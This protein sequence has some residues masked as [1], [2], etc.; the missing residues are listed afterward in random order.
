MSTPLPKA[1]RPT[2]VKFGVLL[3][4][5]CWAVYFSFGSQKPALLAAIDA[6]IVDAMFRL[7]G[8]QPTTG[9]VTIVDIDEKS[10][11]RFGQWPWPR[12]IVAG[13]V[14]TIYR[15]E[16]LAVG[17]DILF[18]EPD[19]TSPA[20]VITRYPQ[21]F[22]QAVGAELEQRQAAAE[23][24]DHDHLLGEAV[25][26]GPA[27]LGYMLLFHDDGLQNEA[28][29]PFPSI[30]VT[31]NRP[32]LSFAHLPL[33]QAY[34]AITNIPSIARAASSEGF[35][36]IFP[37]ANGTVRKSPLFLSLGGI[38]YP[39]LV[40]E[41]FR[42][43]SGEAAAR[44]HLG[45]AENNT[46]YPLLGVS[47]GDHLFRTDEVGNLTINYRGP[48]ATFPRIS[49]ADVLATAETPELR[50]KYVLIG[51]SATGI[52]DRV[53]TPFSAQMA[54][55]EVHAN[56]LDNLLSGDSLIW[57]NYTEIG[58]TYL[59]IGLF[60][61]LLT[62]ALVYLRPLAGL[63]TGLALLGTV[64]VGGYGF[65][66]IR[67][68]LIGLSY[69][70][71]SLTGML[72]LVTF[73]N[74]FTEGRRKQYLR[75]TFSRYVSPS[76]VN[77]LLQNQGRIDSLVE[78]LD[79][80]IFFSDIRNFTRQSEV[81]PPA[82]VGTFLN[83]YLSRMTGI[84]NDH[85]GMVDKFI[86]DGIMAVWGAPLTDD[87]H[88]VNAVAAALTMIEA[89]RRGGKELQL[90]NT[91]I[92]IGIG[93]NSGTVSA[94]NFGSDKRFTYTVLGDNVNLAARVEGLTKYYGV[95]LLL[96]EAT[97]ELLPPEFPCR[98]IDRVLVKG[99]SQPVSLYTPEQILFTGGA[100]EVQAEK[101]GFSAALDSYRQGDFH[102]AHTLFDDLSARFP[103]QLYT[104]Y[105]DR[106]R[107]LS[108]T[109]APADWQEI[110][111]HN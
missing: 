60:G 23:R 75:T 37:D 27:V 103:K 61:T 56:I 100:S 86:G 82:R 67:N 69:I 12:D 25:G 85:H 35:F 55:V 7:R 63:L 15:A 57:E 64:V 72:L 89:I 94:G 111:D 18:A 47:C 8:P 98:F 99:R 38:P 48:V 3:V 73:G 5:F 76:V 52:M 40:F 54:G 41:M 26:T 42:I 66:V 44:L 31:L 1:L 107:L 29:V 16:P 95:P 106:C 50:G 39:S 93:I 110:W 43:G 2:P 101:A 11:R 28:E 10:L 88:A 30:S 24:L 34:R 58:L 81:L 45:T 13:L 68:E 90:G 96:T 84:I 6:R 62:Y 83:R 71:L 53:A 105:R 19:R 70:L 9:A 92:E 17:F 65:L 22:T 49:A 21:L 33:P 59:V 87:R 109:Q 97:A 46:I 51:S 80:T 74:Y 32:E 77:R 20:T 78:S 108:G 102:K 91:G 36:N 104:L 79:V 4:L 14:E